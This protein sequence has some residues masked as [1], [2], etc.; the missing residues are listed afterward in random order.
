MIDKAERSGGCEV[1]GHDLEQ[2]SQMLEVPRVAR[3]EREL[4]RDGRGGDQEIDYARTASLATGGRY[5]GICRPVR[6]SGIRVERHW[7]KGGF[8][9]LQAVLATC[10]LGG[11]PGGMWSGRE[12]GKRHRRDRELFGKRGEFQPLQVDDD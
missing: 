12:L 7:F 10:P 11:V 3:V 1:D 5:G 2:V 8:R 9:A 6:A 4:R